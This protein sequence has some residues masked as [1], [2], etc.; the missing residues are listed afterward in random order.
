MR[1]K[2]TALRRLIFIGQKAC[3]IAGTIG[4]IGI[5]G[6]VGAVENGKDMLY[7]LEGI[8]ICTGIIAFSYGLYQTL[9]EALL[10]EYKRRIE[11]KRAHR[12]ATLLC[13]QHNNHL[14]YIECK[15]ELQDEQ[16]RKNT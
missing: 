5:P 4:V 14:N 9:D 8:V 10:W 12:A 1:K 2:C 6:V 16:H 7:G 3:W 13:T 11:K 15:E